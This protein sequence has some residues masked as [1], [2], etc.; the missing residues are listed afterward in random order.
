MPVLLVVGKSFILFNCLLFGFL[1]NKKQRRGR[2][3][4]TFSLTWLQW[5]QLC[6]CRWKCSLWGRRSL[7]SGRG[8]GSKLWSLTHSFFRWTVR[9]RYTDSLERQRSSW[10][11]VPLAMVGV[12]G[13]GHHSP[14]RLL[15]NQIFGGAQIPKMISVLVILKLGLICHK[16][17]K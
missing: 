5:A 6:N 16:D 9:D 4:C 14:S 11:T 17:A 3:V 15:L 1:S 13:L 2:L 10:A 12:Q 7:R 8:L